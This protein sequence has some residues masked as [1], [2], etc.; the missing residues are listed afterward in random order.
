ME[1]IEVYKTEMNQKMQNDIKDIIAGAYIYVTNPIE[2][3]NYISKRL[4]EVYPNKLNWFVEYFENGRNDNSGSCFTYD[5]PYIFKCY[6]EN[7]MIKI[8]ALEKNK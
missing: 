3:P 4:N 6:F 5:S 8:F 7:A 2:R 1:K